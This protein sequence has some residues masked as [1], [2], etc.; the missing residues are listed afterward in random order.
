MQVRG[1]TTGVVSAPRPR[2]E[3]GT[4]RLGEVLSRSRPISLTLIVS[5]LYLRILLPVLTMLHRRP[6][7]LMPE[8]AVSSVGFLWG[9]PPGSLA[10]GESVGRTECLFGA[11]DE[12]AVPVIVGLG[13]PSGTVGAVADDILELQQAFDDAELRGDADRLDALLADDFLSIGEQGYQLAK[14]EWV[15]RHRDFRYLSL[16]T[17]E[18]DVRHYGVSG[19]LRSGSGRPTRVGGE[20][21]HPCS[22][23]PSS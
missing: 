6:C 16:E 2:L 14:R 17:T 11:L 12:G 15:D 22:R 5:A 23:I 20:T 9:P 1:L 8:N 13:P 3:R 7:R 18:F 10:C 19:R 4:Y 21:M